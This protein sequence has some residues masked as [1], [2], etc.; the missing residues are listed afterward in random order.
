MKESW[1]KD[2]PKP[3]GAPCF[4]PSAAG[5][6]AKR[7]L[8]CWLSGVAANPNGDLPCLLSGVAASPNG[9][10]PCWL[11]GVAGAK[12][13]LDAAPCDSM[14][15]SKP[16]SEPPGSAWAA[17]CPT[18]GSAEAEGARAREAV[19]GRGGETGLGE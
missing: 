2:A 18:S 6:G 7:G 4:F 19:G 8:L 11:S 1:P 14:S 13:G 16:E 3:P 12:E 17:T 10:L 15:D 9:D 5:E